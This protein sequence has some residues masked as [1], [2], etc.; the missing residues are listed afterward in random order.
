MHCVIGPGY[1]VSPRSKI[2]KELRTR[3]LGLDSSS[4]FRYGYLYNINH[5][6]G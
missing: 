4:K 6:G 3:L 1:S 5:R 2:P